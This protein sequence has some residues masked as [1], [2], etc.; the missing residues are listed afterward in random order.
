MEQKKVGKARY[1]I[2]ELDTQ[3]I[4]VCQVWSYIPGASFIRPPDHQ[5]SGRVRQRVT[6]V[7]SAK[8]RL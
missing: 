1:D 4:A 5:G 8:W 2:A 6:V 3:E 7:P